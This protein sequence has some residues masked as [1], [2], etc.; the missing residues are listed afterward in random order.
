MDAMDTCCNHRWPKKQEFAGFGI[1]DFTSR[2]SRL[3][4]RLVAWCAENATTERSS[5]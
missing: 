5:P 1:A 3:S 4:A 2:L